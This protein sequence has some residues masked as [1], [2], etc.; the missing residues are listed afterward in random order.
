M[1]AKSGVYQVFVILSSQVMRFMECFGFSS[2]GVAG[3]TGSLEATFL[4]V[5]I[6]VISAAAI[7][8]TLIGD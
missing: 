5:V 6:S 4:S 3:S 7:G 1:P 2:V 8:D